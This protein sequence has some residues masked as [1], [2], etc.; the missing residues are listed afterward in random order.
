M[1]PVHRPLG[2]V[3]MN[4]CRSRT[5]NWG[6]GVVRAHCRVAL[7]SA[8][9]ARARNPATGIDLKVSVL[10]SGF[11]PGSPGSALALPVLVQKLSG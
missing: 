2:R 1:L 6:R 9:L 8:G 3:P 5:N 10:T 11:W 4:H 7:Q